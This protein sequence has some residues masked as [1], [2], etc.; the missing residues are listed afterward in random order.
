MSFHIAF[1]W[2]WNLV[3]QPDGKHYKLQTR[4]LVREGTPRRRAKQLSG[5]RKKKEQS[6]HG[7]PDTETDRPTDR[8]S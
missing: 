1:V 4:A 3:S 7:V 6:G 5:K 2:L 8:P